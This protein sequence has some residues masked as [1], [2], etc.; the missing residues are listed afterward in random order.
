MALKIDDNKKLLIEE[1]EIKEIKNRNKKEFKKEN[2][3]IYE[4]GYITEKTVLPIEEKI[5]IEQEYERINSETSRTE[6][7]TPRARTS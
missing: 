3:L 4:G 2:N 1:E 6:S 5:R 7:I